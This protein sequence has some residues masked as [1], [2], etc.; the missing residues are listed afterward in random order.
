M[1]MPVV[2]VPQQ[3]CELLLV[4]VV[5]DGR[6]LPE[7]LERLHIPVPD[8][9]IVACSLAFIMSPDNLKVM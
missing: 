1:P 2:D 7:I 5:F 9:E 6:K 4:I 8:L 3:V